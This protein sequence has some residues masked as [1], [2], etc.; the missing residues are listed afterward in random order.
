VPAVVF[1]LLAPGCL[2]GWSAAAVALRATDNDRLYRWRAVGWCIPLGLVG[3]ALVS[4]DPVGFW[5]AAGLSLSA[6]LVFQLTIANRFQRQRAELVLLASGIADIDRMDGH[7]FEAYLVLLFARKGF[8]VA[9]SPQSGDFGAD[10]VLEDEAGRIC[11]QA[12]RY[13]KAVGNHAVMEV[14]ASKAHYGAN[15]AIVVTNSGFTPAAIIQARETGVELWDRARLVS[16][17]L[18]T[19]K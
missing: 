16:E 14:V 17:I 5:F 8:R 3:C 2:I 15:R 1:A 10:L 12:K 18:T 4:G 9:R 19:T 6:A 7:A 13:A 11:V